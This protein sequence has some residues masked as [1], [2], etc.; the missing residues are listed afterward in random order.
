MLREVVTMVM[1]CHR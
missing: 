1:R